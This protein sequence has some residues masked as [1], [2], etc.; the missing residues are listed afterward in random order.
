MDPVV[1]G[2]C[3][4]PA[5][6]VTHYDVSANMTKNTAGLSVSSLKYNAVK[7]TNRSVNGRNYI[8]LLLEVLNT[9]LE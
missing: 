7:S 4:G 2:V 6:W 3:G 8:I 9:V 1:E 5:F